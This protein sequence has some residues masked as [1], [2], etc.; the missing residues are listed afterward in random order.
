MTT[1]QNPSENL[2]A[3]K[4]PEKKQLP[5]RLA[6][7]RQALEDE[8]ET[9]EKNGLSSTLLRKGTQVKN[10]GSSRWYEFTVDYMPVM[11]ADTP[12]KLIVGKDTYEVTVISTT[13]HTIVVACSL[14]LPPSMEQARLENGATVLMERLIKRIEDNSERENSAAARLLD[15]PDPADK[16]PFEEIYSIKTDD[17]VLGD[18]NNEAQTAAVKSALNNNVTYIWGPPGTGK[19]SVIAQIIHNLYRNERSVLLIS[20]TNTAVDGAI[21]KIDKEY[22]ECYQEI[23]PYPLLRLGKAF[24][25]LP[26]RLSLEAHVEELGKELYTRKEEIEKQEQ[27]GRKKLAEIDASFLK[28][29]WLAKTR[30]P[31]AGELLHQLTTLEADALH[32]KKHFSEAEKLYQQEVE[33]HPEYKHYQA[34]LLRVESE[35]QRY[36]VS[37]EKLRHASETLESLPERL[38]HARTELANHEQKEALQKR[39]SKSLSG[40]VLEKHIQTH[41]NELAQLDQQEKNNRSECQSLQQKVLEYEQKSSLSKLFASKAKIEQASDRI[42]LLDRQHADI[43]VRQS[44]KKKTLEDYQKQLSDL[45]EIKRQ[46]Q[47]LRTTNTK[48]YWFKETINLSKAEGRVQAELMQLDADFQASKKRYQQTC[49][50]LDLLKIVHDLIESKHQLL[51]TRREELM[52]IQK[53]LDGCRDQYCSIVA[54]EIDITNVWHSPAFIRDK[55]SAQESYQHLCVIRERSKKEV[56]AIDFEALKKEKG[57]LEEQLR[58]WLEELKEIQQQLA[59]LERESILQ[60]RV[61][62]TTL[63]KSYL[64]DTLHERTFDTVILD[65]ASMASIPALW[66]ACLLAEKNIVIVGDFLQ[67][68]PIVIA[69]TEMAQK[70]LGRDIFDLSGMQQRIKGKKEQAD[71]PENFVVLDHQYRMESAIAEIA[72]MYYGEYCRLRSDDHLP[73]R[74]EERNAFYDWYGGKQTRSPIHLLNTVNF[75]AWVTGIKQGKKKN[76]RLNFFSAAVDVTLAFS[77][78]EKKINECLSKNKPAKQPVVLIV[79]PYKPHVKLIEKYISAQYSDIIKKYEKDNK[80]NISFDN[81]GLVKVGTIHQFQGSEAEIVIF[82]LVVDEP[83]W[84]ANLFMNEPDINADLEKMFNVAVTRAKFQLYFVGNFDYCRKRAKNNALGNLLEQLEKQQLPLLDAKEMFP[85]LTFTQRHAAEI[86]VDENLHKKIFICSESEFTDHFKA[87]LAKAKEQVI[88]FSPFMTKNRISMLLHYLD[89]KVNQGCK[90]IVITKT[91]EEHSKTER[92]SYEDC[93]A[94]LRAHGIHV[95]FKYKMHEKNIFFDRDV[96]WCGSLNILSFSGT[97]GE[98]MTRFHDET[99][100][101]GYL[102]ALD[103]EHLVE[104]SINSKRQRCPLCGGMI[105]A[106]ESDEGG[107]YWKCKQCD[108]VLQPSQP[109]PEDGILRCAKCGAPYAFTMKTQPRWTCTVDSKHYQAIRKG[110][111]KLPEMLKLIPKN[112]Y[113]EVNAYFVE[114]TGKGV[115]ALVVSEPKPGMARPVLQLTD[116]QTIIK[117]YP[118]LAD[119]VRETGISS[120][121]IRDAAKGVQKHAGGYCWRYAD[122]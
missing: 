5:P 117:E 99:I 56:T 19:T 80:V 50:E 74:V 69:S 59:G 92:S 120:K 101:E 27:Q 108:F 76:S 97:T 30:L 113:K 9:I 14:P 3:K 89:E 102:T 121:S 52:A 84:R 49:E 103:I 77:L 29:E 62:G 55:H 63:A 58:K 119:A 115:D 1:V 104:P 23:T 61:I 95:I 93:I 36:E 90:I 107:F 10:D 70:W 98:V 91:L 87:D 11:P 17:F 88:I 13:E 40:S 12:C 48:D 22:G 116:D 46:L 20:H 37:A 51:K 86:D 114:K 53:Q 109:Y 60:A 111:L 45:L 4:A 66:C 25:E 71:R 7:F 73:F 54:E 67:L 112:R 96:V 100:F 34:L 32:A 82:D 42:V 64:S 24:Q 110:D 94:V 85:R 44:N 31:K 68:S 72:N 8:I 35:R 41:K 15:C 57:E 106:A 39:E 47:M 28:K 118:S 75:H 6:E 81:L 78:I 33:N 38:I 16:A 83:H 18:H 79:A 26:E 65:E 2:S 43:V 21:A 105:I 122:E